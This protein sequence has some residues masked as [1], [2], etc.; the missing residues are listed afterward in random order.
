MLD[1]FQ[2]PQDLINHILSVID[3]TVGQELV[4]SSEVLKSPRASAVMFLLGQHPN[5][6][7]F[8]PCIILNKRSKKVKQPGDLCCPGGSISIRVDSFFSKL[9]RMRMSPL[10][11]WPYWLSWCNRR[12]KD[13]R[14]LS[15][16][17]AT[18]LR[19]S[20]EEMR[21]NPFGV[22]FLGPL[23]SQRLDMFRR[24]IFPLAGWISSQ[25]RFFP[26]WEV[27]KVVYIPLRDLLNINNYRRL[28]L[29]VQHFN[30]PGDSRLLEDFP[31]FRHKNS[32]EKELLWGATF[33]IVMVF[34]QLIFGFTPPP[35]SSLPVFYETLAENYLSGGG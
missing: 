6:K 3:E 31:C 2:K 23:P 1:L 29:N 34:L 4:L 35:V 25:K 20:L 28:Q 18:G 14:C 30:S 8:E 12:P 10:G 32:D 13:A 16:L 5:R 22:R 11:R 19:E 27:E 26:N 17:F 7:E 21:L 33:R 15:L 9:L 24:I